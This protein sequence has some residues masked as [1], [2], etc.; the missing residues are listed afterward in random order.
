M[1]GCQTWQVLIYLSPTY[2]ILPDHSA[3]KQEINQKM[4][5]KSKWIPEQIRHWKVVAQVQ[6]EAVHS[7]AQ[8]D[9]PVSPSE[10]CSLQTHR[11]KLFHCE[12]TRFHKI[13]IE[14]KYKIWTYC[15]IKGS[16]MQ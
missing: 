15:T 6:T 10:L 16:E 8:E 12:P 11:I 13:K 5:Q 1:F 3:A 4:Q 9:T 2:T 7:A 14:R